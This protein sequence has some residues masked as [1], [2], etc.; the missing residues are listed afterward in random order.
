MFLLRLFS[1]LTVLFLSSTHLQ[2]FEAAACSSV[3]H[4]RGKLLPRSTDHAVFF[5]FSQGLSPFGFLRTF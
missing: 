4:V 1:S 2:A 3:V 5:L